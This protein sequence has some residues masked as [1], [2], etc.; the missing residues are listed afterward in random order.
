MQGAG[1]HL[2]PRSGDPSHGVCAMAALRCAL[3]TSDGWATSYLAFLSMLLQT[4]CSDLNAKG[5]IG[6]SDK[7]LILM[8]AEAIA[9]EAADL[10]VDAAQM[11][12]L[13]D[14]IEVAVTMVCTP[15]S[16]TGHVTLFSCSASSCCLQPHN[17]LDLLSGE[18]GIFTNHCCVHSK[19]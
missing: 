15:I 12:T 6:M 7:S 13:V 9:R 17:V 19:C 14:Q 18:E 4:V 10:G 5:A 2:A 1:F 3:M 16:K 11:A 8:M